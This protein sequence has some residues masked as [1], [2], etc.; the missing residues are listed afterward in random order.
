MV[1]V[2]PIIRWTSK[3]PFHNGSCHLL[4]DTLEELDRFAPTIGLN[5]GWFQISASRHPHYD[6]TP[7]KR[8]Q[9]VNR[10]AKE[11]T[12]QELAELLK[13]I[14]RMPPH[15]ESRIVAHDN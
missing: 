2:D 4:A 5:P 11:V 3:K 6:L 13:T 14:E 10:G 15:G 8:I 1:Y 7:G 12:I 9:A